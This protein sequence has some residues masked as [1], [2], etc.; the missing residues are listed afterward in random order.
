MKSCGTLMKL[1]TSLILMNKDELYNTFSIVDAVKSIGLNPVWMKPG[2]I[3][4]QRELDYSRMIHSCCDG[5]QKDLYAI[6]ADLK[7]GMSVE[8]AL[9]AI[10]D[11]RSKDCDDA[12]ASTIFTIDSLSALEKA[13][14]K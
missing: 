8:D 14:V 9:K 2:T 7:G 13:D 11:L 1:G 6:M 3:P 12:V 4:S 5:I 10:R